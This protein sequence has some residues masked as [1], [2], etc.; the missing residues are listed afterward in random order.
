LP[1]LL[2]AAFNFTN[3]SE[4]AE[5]LRL[6]LAPGSS[7]GGARPKASLRDRNNHLTIAKFPSKTDEYSVVLWEA[8]ALK[9][10]SKAGI[11]VPLWKVEKIGEK[12]VLI[13]RRFDRNDIGRIPYLS[14]MSMLNTKDNSLYSYLEIADAIRL[15]GAQVTLDLKELWRR[16][17]FSI[18]ISNTD[19]HLRNHGFLYYACALYTRLRLIISENLLN[20]FTNL[21]IN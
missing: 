2:N 8:L 4:T 6:L 3:D 7:L 14:A 18:M 16:I 12:N 9:L 5:E 21:F 11:R 15:H 19:D 20:I 17:V 10:A 13:L 1:K